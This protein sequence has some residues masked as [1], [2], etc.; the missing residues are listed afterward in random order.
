MTDLPVFTHFGH[1]ILK[2]LGKIVIGLGY[3]SKNTE[4][5]PNSRVD[6][7]SGRV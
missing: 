3:R 6:S 2:N 5:V 1:L 7:T 4:T